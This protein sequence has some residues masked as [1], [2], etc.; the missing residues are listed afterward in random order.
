MLQE[1]NARMSDSEPLRGTIPSPRFEVSSRSS[2]LSRLAHAK[3]RLRTASSSRSP[4]AS[5]SPSP[6]PSRSAS[7]ST[8]ARVD[9]ADDLAADATPYVAM[10]SEHT[11]L[12]PSKTASA[13]ASAPAPAVVTPAELSWLRR[14]LPVFVQPEVDVANGNGLVKVFFRFERQA[15]TGRLDCK[16]CV[17]FAGEASYNRV[18]EER[19]NVLATFFYRTFNRRTYK[20]TADINY[21]EF[22]GVDLAPDAETPWESIFSFDHGG[23]QRWAQGEKGDVCC[24]FSLMHHYR[25]DVAFNAWRLDAAAR[26]LVFLNTCNHMIGERDNNP[27]LLKREWRDYACQEGDADD[28]FAYVVDH[29]PTKCN[30]YSLVCCWRARNG[31]G[32]CDRHPTGAVSRHGQSIYLPVDKASA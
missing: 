6:S 24:W 17:V 4:S 28:A 9:D 2:Q 19:E 11:A 13:S 14:C 30:L 5:A 27:R 16:L 7:P 10:T 8:R 1:S 21:M 20:R 22:R 15:D 31:G 23:E 18:R 3:H 12:S 32:C 29:V 25:V 26:P